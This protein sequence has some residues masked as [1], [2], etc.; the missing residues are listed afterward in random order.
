MLKRSPKNNHFRRVGVIS[1]KLVAIGGTCVV[2]CLF[3]NPIL[4][5]IINASVWF[6]LET[7]S[8]LRR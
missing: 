6:L 5:N 8:E 1:L 4:A 7:H 2:A 3:P